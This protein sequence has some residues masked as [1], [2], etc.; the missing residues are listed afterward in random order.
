MYSSRVAAASPRPSRSSRLAASSRIAAVSAAA[1][2]KT[3]RGTA[4]TPRRMSARRHSLARKCSI[5][6]VLASVFR[7][8]HGLEIIRL[9]VRRP[10]DDHTGPTRGLDRGFKLVD[11][12]ART[13]GPL[14][15]VDAVLVQLAHGLDHAARAPD[16]LPEL[17]LVEAVVA[18]MHPLI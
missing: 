17:L 1:W 9:A 13:L 14:R 8:D 4:A 2:P 18:V 7:F 11:D 16:H 10:V 6:M 15:R 3:G 12:V 5:A